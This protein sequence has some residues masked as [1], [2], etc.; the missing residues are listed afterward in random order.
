M[1]NV[2]YQ[3][4]EEIQEI[5]EEK[6]MPV[7]LKV[8]CILSFIYI[9]IILIPAI[10]GLFSGP[11]SETE[12]NETFQNVSSFIPNSI[13]KQEKAR[14][15]ELA[16]EKQK[17]MN[18]KFYLNAT[19]NIWVYSLG[20]FGVFKMFKKRQRS[21][22]YLYLV[23][24]FLSVFSLYL[25]LPTKLISM[26]DVLSLFLWSGIMVSLYTINLKHLTK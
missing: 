25:I 14:L 1:E 3:E 4:V 18:D 13:S 24:S 16:Y 26:E 2:E 5:Q 12:L 9:G 19:I 21:G 15:L 7:F 17:V 23:Y 20:F 22:Y 11:M 8:L 10:F 6:K